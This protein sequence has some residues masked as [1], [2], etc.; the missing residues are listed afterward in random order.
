MQ[1]ATKEQQIIFTEREKERDVTKRG[2][3][4]HLSCYR[5]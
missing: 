4:A 5:H 3:K 2:G 1:E